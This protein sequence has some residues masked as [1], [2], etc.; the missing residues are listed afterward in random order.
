MIYFD[1]AATT[2]INEKALKALSECSK[3]FF[4]NPSTHYTIGVKTKRLMEESRLKIANAIGA[5]PENIVFTSGGTESN[6]IVLQSLIGKANSESEI[7]VSEIEH[8]SILNVVKK[9][10]NLKIRYI[11]PNKN[12]VIKANEVLDAVNENTYLIVVQMINNELGTIQPIEEISNGINGKGIF[13][14]V[15]AVQAIGHVEIN[16]KGLG[17]TTLSASAHKFNGPKGIGFLYSTIKDI[18]LSYG[19]AQERGIR[20]GTENVPAIAAMAIALEESLKDLKNKQA[21]IMNMVSFLNSRLLSNPLIRLNVENKGYHSIINFRVK[22]VSNEALINLLDLKGVCVSAGSACD[23]KNFEKSHVLSAIGLNDKL[24]N[25][26][27]RL[28][29]SYENTI[30]E[31]EFFINTLMDCINKLAL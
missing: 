28:S 26:S 3:D 6:N 5:S 27:V 20:P 29:L 13:F 21:H 12:G 15:D 8:S 23:G 18:R 7:I 30:E 31:C 16:V 19:G 4:G 24:I 2:R 10:K 1:N 11:K 22:N 14:H 9:Y 25:E 17:M